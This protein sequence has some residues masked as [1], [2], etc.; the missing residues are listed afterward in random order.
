MIPK[1][2]PFK[3]S[4]PDS[5][6]IATKKIKEVPERNLKYKNAQELAE[7]INFND[8]ERYFCIVDGTFIFGDF[9]EAFIKKYNIHVK[10]M[11]I[12]TLSLS[13]ENIDSLRN[14]IVG[15]YVEEL[16]LIVS[17]HFYQ[18]EK[19]N[20]V[21]CIYEKLDV[22]DKFQ[23]A[24]AGNHCKIVS[25]ETMNGRKFVMHGSA[26]LRSNSNI[27]QF[28][29]EESEDLYN[30]NVEIQDSIIDQFKTINKS[31]RGKILWQAVTEQT[32]KSESQTGEKKKRGQQGERANQET[33]SLHSEEEQSKT[34][35]FKRIKF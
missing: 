6:L 7:R 21:K 4:K 3:P 28:N 15:N 17:D 24:S 32:K 10:K 33:D 1:F 20:L 18:H 19:H 31:V 2:T 26:N 8:F 23:L 5:R 14:L 25:F 30:F 9:I 27:E 11:T 13:H 29:F 34:R 16:N 22:L 35:L 12:S